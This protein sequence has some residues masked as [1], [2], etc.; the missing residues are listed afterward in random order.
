ME[1]DSAHGFNI[2]GGTLIKFRR[3]SRFFDA[4]RWL[5]I[6]YGIAA[7]GQAFN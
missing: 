6:F 4:H 7:D 5:N 3:Y 1:A 2:L